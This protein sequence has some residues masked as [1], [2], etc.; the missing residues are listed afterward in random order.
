VPG[1]ML[2]IFAVL[3]LLAHFRR[4]IG[5]CFFTFSMLPVFVFALGFGMIAI[6]FNTKSARELSQKI[7]TLTPDTKLAFLEC[8]PSGLPFYLERT[9]PLITRDG[10]EI[11]SASNYILFSLKH[12]PAWPANLV[13]LT[14]FDQWISQRKTP[15]YLVTRDDERPKLEEIG[16]PPA[17]IHPLTPPYIG[18][19]L[20]PQ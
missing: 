3:G 9:A 17:D 14:N 10:N 4:D 19:L 12:D 16:V 15:I 2:F 11:T 5:L 13:P 20:T 7:Q 8:F 6:V 1:I 18:V